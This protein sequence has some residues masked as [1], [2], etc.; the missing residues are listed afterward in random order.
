MLALQNKSAK[1]WDAFSVKATIPLPNY[2]G[3]TLVETDEDDLKQ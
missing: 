1:L 2:E 3:S